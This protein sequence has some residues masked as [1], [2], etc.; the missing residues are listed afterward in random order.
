MKAFIPIAGL[1]SSFG[2]GSQGSEDPPGSDEPAAN[3]GQRKSRL[4]QFDTTA[5]TIHEHC[6]SHSNELQKCLARCGVEADP[7][8]QEANGW[9]G[10]TQCQPLWKEVMKA[11]SYTNMPMSFPP[12]F[13][14][15]PTHLT[16]VAIQ[17]KSCCHRFFVNQS[18]MVQ[19]CSTEAARYENCI[20]STACEE[21]ELA[22]LR[23]TQTRMMLTMSGSKPS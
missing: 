8:I 9:K 17:F 11:L 13:S 12:S 5:Y 14:L 1:F 23:C 16:A 21:A 10:T 4:R 18:Q 7:M 15:S 19:A 2:S 22:L 20:G 6:G 3:A